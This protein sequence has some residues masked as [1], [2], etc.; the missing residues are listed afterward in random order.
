[1][2]SKNSSYKKKQIA[3]NPFCA[4]ASFFIET[5]VERRFK[6]SALNLKV[7]MAA[8]FNLPDED[9]KSNST[10]LMSKSWI[11]LTAYRMACTALAFCFTSGYLRRCFLKALCDAQFSDIMQFT[12]V[13]GQNLPLLLRSAECIADTS[14]QLDW[15]RL[16]LHA[17]INQ[18]LCDITAK[19]IQIFGVFTVTPVEG[20]NLPLLLRLAECIADTS[21]QLD[22]QRLC[23][24]Q[25]LSQLSE[26]LSA[27]INQHLFDTAA[28]F[29][30]I[31]GLSSDQILVTQWSVLAQADDIKERDF[32]Q[33][34]DTA[35]QQANID[36][37]IAIHFY[38][39]QALTSSSSHEKYVLLKFGLSW[40]Y[41]TSAT[42][43]AVISLQL[44][45]YTTCLQDQFKPEVTTEGVS[46]TPLRCLS[47]ELQV[48]PIPSPPKLTSGQYHQLDAVI[49]QHLI[50]GDIRTAFLLQALFHH[51]NQDCELLLACMHLVES[52]ASVS[53]L[54]PR[55]QE[56]LADDTLRRPK[57]AFPTP[58]ARMRSQSKLLESDNQNIL[59]ALYTLQAHQTC[60]TALFGNIICGFKLS[61]ALGC[62]YKDVI[63]DPEPLNRLHPTHDFD[64]ATNLLNLASLS[65]YDCTQYVCSQIVHLLNTGPKDGKF[66]LWS[67]DLE[68]EFNCI[69]D[70]TGCPLLLGNLLMAS[71]L[72]LTETSQ[73]M[74]YRQVVEG[75]ILAHS[76]YTRVCHME[77][78]TSVLNISRSLVNRLLDCCQWP[79]MVCT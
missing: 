51:T 26:V 18:Y 68:S 28:K 7:F 65:H 59:N 36:P 44:E 47:H 17:I 40:M 5:V 27:L 30:Q 46:A 67:C 9:K 63:L 25:D 38:R 62:D 1:M 56:Y 73:P 12:P 4:L 53:Q 22:W 42:K 61:V 69:L 13:E 74:A 58:L 79:L 31:A 71:D 50:V 10:F 60:S 2:R 20:Q 45:L 21:L 19:I 70:L 48:T 75:L 77:G 52:V 57:M 14:L 11:A 6:E 35:F 72:P 54:P 55:I 64:V 34:C 33:R 3:I 15:Q 8:F 66:V 41:K 23:L 39:S 29:A 49:H 32:W 78:I 24:Q 37:E 43:E 76:S 16:C